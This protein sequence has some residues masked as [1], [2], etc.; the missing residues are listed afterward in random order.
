MRFDVD[1]AYWNAIGPFGGWIAERFVRAVLAEPDAAGDPVSASIAFVGPM[2]ADAFDV[3]PSPLRKNRSTDFWYA[4]LTQD[5]DGN[6]AHCAHATFVLAT[7]RETRV[8]TEA[9]AP[10]VA[11]PETLPQRDPARAPFPFLKR[12]D[13]RFA[14]GDI[15]RGDL[16][17]PAVMWVRDAEPRP[18]DFGVLLSLCDT[19][20]PQIFYR[21]RQPVPV[22]TVTLNAFFHATRADLAAAGDDYLLTETRMRGANAGYYDA[23]TTVWSRS[24]KLLATSEQL[25]WYRDPA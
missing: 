20:V 16:T 8:F 14:R 3:A 13:A 12:F 11:A 21:F 4:T 1:P 7:R 24:G 10:A 9:A 19:P 18:L 22:S 25:V 17:L 6:R 2:R 5:Q 15:L 23:V